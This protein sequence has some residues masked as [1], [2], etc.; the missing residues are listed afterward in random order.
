MGASLVLLI[1]G[2]VA[3]A[4]AGGL[5]YWGR[6]VQRD[7]NLLRAAVPTRAGEVMNAFPGELVSISGTSR[8][9]RDHKSQHAKE[10][11]VYY[12]FQV[13]R[14]YERTSRDSKGNRSTSRASETIASHESSVPFHV[15]D[16]TG[17]AR[18]IPDGATFDAKQILNRYEPYAGEAT[19]ISIGS[20]S[21]ALGSG[22]DRTLGHRYVESII[23]VDAPVF[24][25]GVVDEQGNVGRPEGN[26]QGRRL[27]IS[28]RSEEALRHEWQRRARWLA[29]SAI[30]LAGL[31]FIL[32]ITALIA[33]FV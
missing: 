7:V 5:L 21:V 30:G 6:R 20:F 9:D 29:Y 14:E 31:A 16:S 17:R 26:S 23:P 25:L 10:P 1:I 28:Y 33:L 4:V 13:V 2:I 27:F 8:S 22:G 32:W 12:S 24:A 11:C 3:L 15:E 19:T 18:V